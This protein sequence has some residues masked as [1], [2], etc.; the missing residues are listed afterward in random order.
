MKISKEEF[1]D[2]LKGAS[3]LFEDKDWRYKGFMDMI[4]Q[5]GRFFDNSKCI[6]QYEKGEE[7]QCYRN[8][9]LLMMEHPELTYVEGYACGAVLPVHHAW[10]VTKQG[11]V[12]DTTWPYHEEDLYYGIPI[13]R[14]FLL[15]NMLRTK[16][17]GILDN[18]PKFVN[19]LITGEIS[20]DEIK[21]IVLKK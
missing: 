4:Y 7:C 17:Y 3:V 6:D 15:G 19:Q 18:N 5:E 2:F 16:R 13:N 10:C 21:S 20:I 11:E 1:I 8:A 14:E 9:A 12:I